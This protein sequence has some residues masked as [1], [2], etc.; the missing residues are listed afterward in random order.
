MIQNAD[1]L[2]MQILP[3]D[4]NMNLAMQSITLLSWSNE[5]ETSARK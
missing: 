5:D 2:G 1:D 4:K 3:E